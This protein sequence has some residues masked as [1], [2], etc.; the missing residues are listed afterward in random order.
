MYS[1]TVAAFKLM[2]ALAALRKRYMLAREPTTQQI[3]ED[4]TEPRAEATAA[5]RGT[6]F[7]KQS[8]VE[9]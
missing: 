3:P 1:A 7:A 4:R 6:V 9:L 2:F 8:G 5:E